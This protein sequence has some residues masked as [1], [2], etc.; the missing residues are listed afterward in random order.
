MGSVSGSVLFTSCDRPRY[1]I[2]TDLMRHLLPSLLLATALLSSCSEPAS[3]SAQ[4]QSGSG[5]ANGPA[6]WEA[7]R[8]YT[9]LER[10]RFMDNTG[11]QQPAEA[12][13]VLVPQ[14]WKH[15]GG[16]VWKSLQEC[17][18]EM[19]GADFSIS[20][21][22]GAVRFRSLRPHSWTASSDQMMMQGLQMQA[23]QG[24]CAVGWAMSGEEYLRQVLVPNELA[25]ATVVE[26]EPNP[27][28]ERAIAEQAAAYQASAQRYGGRAEMNPS[29][30]TARVKWNDG[31][32]GLVLVSVRNV[33]LITPNPYTGEQHQLSMSA[34]TERSWVRFPGARRNEAE[35]FLA[36]LKSSFRTN[37]AWQQAVDGYFAQLGREQDREHH[38]RMAAIDQQ[39]RNMTAA[40]NQ[41]M[42]DIQAQ[43][44]AN[45][46]RHNARMDA[47]DANM[48][49][50]EGQQASQDRQ[51]TRFVQTIRE[52][53]TWRGDNG[54]VE[55][56]S[57]Y[58]QAWSRGDGTYILSNK[59]GFDPAAVFQDRNWTEMK[60]A[61]P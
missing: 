54:A 4:A 41:R 34:T 35:T 39:T 2:N 44:A 45:T 5:G 30:V 9:V 3:P 16:V 51:H 53:E 31:T 15:E 23:S 43:G 60:R 57:G 59:P 36:N 33:L 25:G 17:R 52:V 27:E 37:P 42:A 24:G 32:E 48:R 50:W 26:V 18:S 40:H 10:V 6:R 38:I 58:D 28:A 11:F 19:V 29:A 21:P 1:I 22:D 7:G 55:L 46:Q 56:S 49:S 14:G 12:F 47:M 13:S 20:S 61:D 8:D